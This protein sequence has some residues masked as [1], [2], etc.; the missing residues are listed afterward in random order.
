MLIILQD[1]DSS[2]VGSVNALSLRDLEGSTQAP[3]P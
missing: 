2:A 1:S 3:C